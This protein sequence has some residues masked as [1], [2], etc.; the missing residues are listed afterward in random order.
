MKKFLRTMLA[1]AVLGA[2]GWSAV[3]RR[4]RAPRRTMARWLYFA[5]RRWAPRAAQWS[6]RSGRRLVRFARRIG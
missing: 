1:G 6:T 5:G 3:L 2:F 4:T